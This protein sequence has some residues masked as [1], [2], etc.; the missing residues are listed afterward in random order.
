MAV[1]MFKSKKFGAF[2]FFAFIFT[3]SA[4]KIHAQEEEGG[5]F[6]IEQPRVFYGGLVIGA[7][8]TQVDGDDYAGYH[9]IGLNVGGIVYAQLKKHLA[10]SLEI[11]YSQKG[12]KSSSADPT[13]AAIINGTTY[14]TTNYGIDIN[15][16]EIPLMINY[17]DKRKSHAGV[18]LSY[19]RLVSSTENLVTYPSPPPVDLTKYPFK[20]GGLDA[21]AGVQ[22]HIIKGLFLNVRFQYSVVPIRTSLPPYFARATQYNNMYVVRLMYLFI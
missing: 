14:Y 21:I 11:L 8:F 1:S 9:K 5:G 12:S 3:L 18:G 15:Y 10:L 13:R 6:Y 20:P 7:N 22:L 16:A 17:F 19:S 4:A 2:I